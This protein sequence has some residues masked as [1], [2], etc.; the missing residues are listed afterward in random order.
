MERGNGPHL[1]APGAVSIHLGCPVSPVGLDTIHHP[2][3]H[4]H[5]NCVFWDGTV[6]VMEV[7]F[8]LDFEVEIH[9]RKV[10]LYCR[11]QFLAVLE[12]NC[13]PGQSLF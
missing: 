9:S 13:E 4:L 2:D 12:A 1:S 10:S 8:T 5:I 6:E 7:K 11:I 3:G